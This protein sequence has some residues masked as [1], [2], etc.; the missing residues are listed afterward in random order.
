MAIDGRSKLQAKKDELTEELKQIEEE[1]DIM[2]QD[3]D[4]GASPERVAK[5]KKK[6]KED[7]NQKF[8]ENSIK[9]LENY[10]ATLQKRNEAQRRGLL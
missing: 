8:Y 1:E 2:N 4:E 6:Q 9:K 3:D 10:M 5:K 7:A